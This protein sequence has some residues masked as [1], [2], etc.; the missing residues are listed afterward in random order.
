MQLVNY[1]SEQMKVHS[2]RN[3]LRAIFKKNMQ[4]LLFRTIEMAANSQNANLKQRIN[5]ILNWS[6]GS[7]V[8]LSRDLCLPEI[9]LSAVFVISYPQIMVVLFKEKCYLTKML[10]YL[11]I[12]V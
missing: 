9:L 10:K 5:V 6:Q 1:Y 11:A 2:I 3:Q 4:F 12:Q 8:A 7:L